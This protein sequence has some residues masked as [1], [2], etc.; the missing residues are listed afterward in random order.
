VGSGLV[1]A[2][3]TRF[4]PFGSPVSESCGVLENALSAWGMC[5]VSCH[6]VLKSGWSK[7][8]KSAA[9]VKRFE[10]VN[11]Y[12]VP[13]SSPGKIPAIELALILPW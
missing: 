6:G 13:A 10:L 4:M 12:G 11:K 8:G 3:T 7:Q 2:K 1:S 5:S 9:R